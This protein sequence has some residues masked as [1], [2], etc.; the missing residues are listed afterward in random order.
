MTHGLKLSTGL[1]CTNINNDM[2]EKQSLGMSGVMH[3]PSWR[4]QERQVFIELFPLAFW[5]DIK[6]AIA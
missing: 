1:G 4:R 2:Y 3:L 6:P 5:V